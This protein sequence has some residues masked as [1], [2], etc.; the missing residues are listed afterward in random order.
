MNRGMV[1]GVWFGV[2]DM[3]VMFWAII[4]V[5]SFYQ[6]LEDHEYGLLKKTKRALWNFD[7]G[8]TMVDCKTSTT[9][10]V[11]SG[12]DQYLPLFVLDVC[13][14]SSITKISLFSGA[15]T[16]KFHVS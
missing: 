7:L 10:R 12:V 1:V 15:H 4:C 14:F 8:K 13:F 2:I 6:Q 5:I 11:I 16:R 9:S 3:A